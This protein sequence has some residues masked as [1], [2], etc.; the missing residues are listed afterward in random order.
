MSRARIARKCA[1]VF[2]LGLLGI[3]LGNASTT[4][5][6]IVGYWPLDGNANATFGASGTLVNSP[7]VVADHNGVAGGALAF[8][9]T[10][11]TTGSYVSIAGGGGLNAATAGTISMWIQWNGAQDVSC[12]GTYGHVLGRQSNGIFSNNLIGLGGSDPATAQVTWAPYGTV[13]VVT[14]ATAVGNG[15]WRHVAVTFQSGQQR[16][17]LDG[18]LQGTAATTGSMNNNSAIPLAIGAWIADG[19]SYSTS[20]ID[21]VAIFN[22]VLPI[23]DIRY[24]ASRGVDQW[25]RRRPYQEAV[26]ASSPMAY[27]RFDGDT[28][29]N[30]SQMT[31]SSGFGRH[32]TYSNNVAIELENDLALLSGAAHFNG[33][34]NRG[35]GTTAQPTTSV[36]VEA[37]AKSDTANWNADGAMVSKRDAFIIHPV[38]NSKQLNFYVYTTGWNSVAFNL[39]SIPGFDLQQWH[40]YAG[41]YDPAATTG[42]LQL[43]VDGILRATVDMGTA[44]A[45]NSSSQPVYIGFDNAGARWFDGLIDEVAIYDHAL[46]AGDIFEHY[47]AAAHVPEPSALALLATGLAG[48]AGLL[49]TPKRWRRRVSIARS[50]RTA[51]S[52]H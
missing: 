34:N 41:V 50:E 32:G 29:L 13:P 39:G 22:Q 11:P 35:Q 10:G 5:A 43:Y 25:L 48:L 47:M 7:T 2:V 20:S 3:G 45:I 8:A 6:A 30:G 28:G 31:D 49:S 12:C 46:S 44:G 4:Q 52:V 18:V 37:W 16:L 40:H 15:V 51:G 14:G 23:D 36:T 38:F 26:L 17:Y 27:Y 21:D 19:T 9:S 1:G 24:M 42:E 33:S